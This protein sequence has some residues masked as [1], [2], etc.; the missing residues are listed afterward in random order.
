MAGPAQGNMMQLAAALM[1][2][3]APQSRP[4]AFAQP[5]AGPTNDGG[6]PPFQIPGLNSA[7]SMVPADVVR[8]TQPTAALPSMPPVTVTA[9]APQMQPQ[10]APMPAPEAPAMSPPQSVR[11]DVMA[12]LQQLQ[13]QGKLPEQWKGAFSPGYG[14]PV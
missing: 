1:R 8:N 2:N 11:S 3:R 7:P 12:A 14:E 5:Y 13:A 10:E 6:L 4:A 9:Q